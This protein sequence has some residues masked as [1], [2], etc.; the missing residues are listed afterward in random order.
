MNAQ[1]ASYTIESAAISGKGGIAPSLLIKKL[2][3][4]SD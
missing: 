1:S 2:S 4:F 3:D